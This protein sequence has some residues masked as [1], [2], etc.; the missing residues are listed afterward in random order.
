MRTRGKVFLLDDDELIITMLSRALANDFGLPFLLFRIT[1][2]HT[3]QIPGK[4]RCLVATS[5]GADFQK[6]I[7]GVMGI[8]R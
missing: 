7:F 2:I 3:K 8:H 6:G 5:T 1:G 4:Q